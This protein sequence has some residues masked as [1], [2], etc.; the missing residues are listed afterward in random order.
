[1]ARALAIR[2]RA[3]DRQRP[4]RCQARAIRTGNLQGGDFSVERAAFDVTDIKAAARLLRRPEAAGRPGQQCGVHA[5][6]GFRSLQ[7][8][9]FR[10]DLCKAPSPQRSRRCAPA[11]PALKQGVAERPATPA[12]SMSPRCMARS[13][14]TPG[15]MTRRGRQSPFHY[16]PAKA[17]LLQLTRHLAAELGPH[18]H[19]RQ[20]A[21]ART[22]SRRARAEIRPRGWPRAPC[23]DGWASL[24]NRRPP[25]VPGFAGL[26]LHDRCRPEP[27]WWMDGLVIKA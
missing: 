10:L 7:P 9:R 14:R 13:R 19:P 23:W 11:L 17:A 24:R 26:Q 5:G 18:R 22:F 8:G 12:S 25:A 1:M 2:R 15:F 4:R 21:G 16:G 3:C 20:C 27:G 6:E